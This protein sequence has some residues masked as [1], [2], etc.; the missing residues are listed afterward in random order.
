VSASQPFTVDDI[1]ST[2]ATQRLGQQLFFHRTLPSTNS[3]AMLLAQGGGEHGIVVVAD[4]QTAGRG[5]RSRTWFSPPEMNLYASILIRPLVRKIPAADWLS[6]IPLTTA[7]AAAESIQ[8]VAG[9]SVSLKWPNDLLLEGQKV[10]GILC[11]SGTDESREPFVVIGLGLNV[12]APLTLFPAELATLAT[13]L[14]EQTRQPVDRS[15]LLAQFL[16]DLEHALDELASEGPRRLRHVYATR[17]TTIGKRVRVMVSEGREWDG[18]AV[19][20]G[21]D[22]ALHVHPR[23]ASPQS[24]PRQIVEVRAADVLHVRE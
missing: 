20:I 21:L 3:E 24:T 10:G 9:L 23:E 19:A 11:E 22:G 12:N 14:I 13:S 18:E 2:L 7:I 5:R 4:S 6:W 17:C 8:Q 16:L 1:R 15:R